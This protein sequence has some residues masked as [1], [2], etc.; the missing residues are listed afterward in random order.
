MP[1]DF[2]RQDASAVAVDDAQLHAGVF[3]PQPQGAVAA[4]ASQEGALHSQTHDGSL[5]T[6]EGAHS[7]SVVVCAPGNDGLIGA[8]AEKVLPVQQHTSHHPGV[9]QLRAASDVDV[10]D[11]ARVII[12]HVNVHAFRR[13]KLFEP[14][15]ARAWS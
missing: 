15:R 3:V 8:A 11:T 10:V 12:N 4:S 7:L 13:S 9:T 5:V 1:T 14:A 6:H 2:H